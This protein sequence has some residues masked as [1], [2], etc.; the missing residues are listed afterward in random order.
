MSETVFIRSKKV[1]L[2]FA[3]W[4][5]MAAFLTIPT[6]QLWHHHTVKIERGEASSQLK[7]ASHFKCDIC[8]YLSHSLKHMGIQNPAIALTVP[9][10]IYFVRTS[11]FACA[12][13]DQCLQAFTNK[14]PPLL[15]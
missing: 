10:A 9:V 12:I 7:I 1:L 8:H 5:L 11:F 3:A 4:L 14:G 13:F 6:V 15:P 2:A